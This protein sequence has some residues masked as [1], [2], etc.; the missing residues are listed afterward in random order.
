M[1]VPHKEKDTHFFSWYLVIKMTDVR[2]RDDRRLAFCFRTSV[3]FLLYVPYFC[4]QQ[5]ETNFMK[6]ETSFAHARDIYTGIFSNHVSCFIF[7]QNP[8]VNAVFRVKHD[9]SSCFTKK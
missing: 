6:H 4:G 7:A 8:F 1:G 5:D 2:R 9:V 3:I